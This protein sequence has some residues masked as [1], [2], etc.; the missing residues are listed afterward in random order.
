MPVLSRFLAA[1]VEHRRRVTAMLR[2]AQIFE[3]R[4]RFVRNEIRSASV[5]G[6]Y[7]LRSSSLVACYRHHSADMGALADIFVAGEYVLPE[8]VAAFLGSRERPRILD[9][10]GHVGYFAL[11]A[12]MTLPGASVVSYEPDPSNADVLERCL[13]LNPALADRWELRRAAAAASEGSVAFVAAGTTGSH[14]QSD[15]ARADTITVPAVDVLPELPHFDLVK[16]DVE[17]GEWEILHD[18]RF[19]DLAPPVVALEYH[20]RGA[21]STDPA[22]EARAAMAAGGYRIIPVVE[23]DDGMGTLWGLRNRD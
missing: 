15:G 1:T 13:E 2:R 17:G 7:T 11:Y 9:L 5:T 22:G 18:R 23:K 12:F 8:P 19:A 6:A 21:K 20:V 10:G 3:E 14:I 4:M 16:L